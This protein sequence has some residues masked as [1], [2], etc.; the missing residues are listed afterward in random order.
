MADAKDLKSFGRLL[1]C[2]FES[3]LGY[4]QVLIT[5]RLTRDRVPVEAW[6]G[7]GALF[8]SSHRSDGE[9]VVQEASELV[10]IRSCRP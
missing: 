6:P 2:G 3:R 9:R 7:C 8:S 5:W 1:P 10:C 4:C